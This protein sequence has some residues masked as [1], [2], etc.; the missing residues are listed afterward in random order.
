MPD[1]GYRNAPPS[2]YPIFEDALTLRHF[3]RPGR[4]PAVRSA[5]PPTCPQGARGRL[6]FRTKE[7]YR[8]AAAA[9]R[10]PGASPRPERRQP[11]SGGG[12]GRT[13]AAVRRAARPG[14]PATALTFRPPAAERRRHHR[15]E[16]EPQ[17]PPVVLLRR[18]CRPGCRSGAERRSPLPGGA[19]PRGRREKPAVMLVDADGSP[20]RC[21]RWHSLRPAQ[22]KAAAGQRYLRVPQV[23]RSA[24]KPAPLSAGFRTSTSPLW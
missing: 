22:P 23:P 19:A 7:E 10:A 18:R 4:R 9:R 13:T 2:Q 11:V 6:I 8:F 24:S 3:C 14:R 21:A 12:G 16:A 17:A 15:H 1:Q 20:A 5:R